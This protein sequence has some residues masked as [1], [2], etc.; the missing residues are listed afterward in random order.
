MPYK[1]MGGS[2]FSDHHVQNPMHNIAN[3]CQ[4]CHR[5]TEGQL[6]EDVYGIKSKYLEL[7]EIV[8]KDLVMAHLEA[9]KAWE[10][11]ASEEQMKQALQLIRHGQWRWDYATAAHGAYFHAPEETMRTLGSAIK[12]TGDARRELQK[13][14]FS[15]NFKH[16]VTW[17]D[18]D[19]KVKAQAFIGIDMRS[20]NDDK[21]SFLNGLAKDWW[22]QSS[23]MDAAYRELVEDYI[24][25]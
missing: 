16:E 15:L 7:K 6:K 3:A 23:H 14:L 21:K 22:N 1:T 5:Q 20:L 10:L 2:K 12:A 9:K 19:S 4:Q 17:P 25:K 18:I 24:E 13:I 11:G 8:E